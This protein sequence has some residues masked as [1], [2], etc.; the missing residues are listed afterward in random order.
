MLNS[1]TNTT[2]A[3]VKGTNQTRNPTPMWSNVKTSGPIS[4]ACRSYS[5]GCVKFLVMRWITPFDIIWSILRLKVSKYGL[6][7]G[8]IKDKGTVKMVSSN[9]EYDWIPL[10]YLEL[11]AKTLMLSPIGV[12][13]R[14]LWSETICMHTPKMSESGDS[15]NISSLQRFPFNLE[16]LKL[17]FWSSLFSQTYPLTSGG[18]SHFERSSSSL[19]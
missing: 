5:L 15:F 16:L 4:S 1:I 6:N 10:R 18:R 2:A 12:N 3:K 9:N 8:N 17:N 14:L 7:F 13:P 19:L 11:R